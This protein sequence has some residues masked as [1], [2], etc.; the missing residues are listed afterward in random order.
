MS[1]MQTNFVSRR[2]LL[3]LSMGGLA[4]TTFVRS[5]VGGETL[6]REDLYARF[7]EHGTSG[8]FV[9]YEVDADRLVLVNGGRAEERFVPA[10]TF[11]IP[12]SLIALEIGVVKDVDE[13][14]PY[15]GKPQPIK[16]W[17][18]NMPMREAIVVSNVP[19][20]QELARRIGIA[21]YRQWLDRLGYGNRRVGTVVDRFWL[22]GPLKISAIEQARFV[23]RLAQGKLD[24]SAR[25]QAAVRAILRLEESAGAMLYGKTGWDGKVGWWSGWVDRG[26]RIYSFSLN[27][28]MQK[29][30]DAPKRLEI[31]KALLADFDVL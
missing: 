3:A 25:A 10:S 12:N 13:V 30:A 27:M 8:T 14:I 16:A 22:D 19:V 6:V 24:A 26:G 18:Q 2:A 5:T 21:G 9:L 11:K 1:R 7:Q 23:A 28:P 17:E 31:G 20:Y 15:G 4:A 29:L